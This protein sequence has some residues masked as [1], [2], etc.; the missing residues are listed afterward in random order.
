[1][2]CMIKCKAN[3]LL[4]S[5]RDNFC[6]FA[7]QEQ[8]ASSMYCNYIVEKHFEKTAK[9][10]KVLSFTVAYITNMCLVH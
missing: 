3:I 1:M 8:K 10:T 4:S 6:G 5:L 9:T 2:Y 7:E